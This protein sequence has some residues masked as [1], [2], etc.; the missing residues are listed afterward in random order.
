[1]PICLLK[2]EQFNVCR[3]TENTGS[4]KEDINSIKREGPFPEPMSISILTASLNEVQ[5]IEFWLKGISE[6]YIENKLK[7]IR[8]IIIVDDGS[9]DGT[10]Q[11]V[12]EL[13]ET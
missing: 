13:R 3:K 7:F 9:I 5:N 2:L 6:I 4:V 8:E 12:L 11:K 10:V 1:M